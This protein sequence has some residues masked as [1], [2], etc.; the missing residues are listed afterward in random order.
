MWAGLI[1][2][3]AMRTL[4]SVIAKLTVP[5]VATA[6][7]IEMKYRDPEVSGLVSTFLAFAV[8]PEFVEGA[9]LAMKLPTES[10]RVIALAAL[11][12]RSCFQAGSFLRTL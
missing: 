2:P 1:F 4:I 10:E 9:Q 6:V 11:P 12:R 3:F 5:I 8:S 7:Q